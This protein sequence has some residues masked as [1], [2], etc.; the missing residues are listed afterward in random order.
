MIISVIYTSL[1]EQAS[2]TVES[3]Y[4]PIIPRTDSQLSGGIRGSKTS[5]DI[6]RSETPDKVLV[7]SSSKESEIDELTDLLMSSLKNNQVCFG[8]CAGKESSFNK[9][10]INCLIWGQF[11]YVQ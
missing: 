11:R 9:L 4:E 6:R 10:S 8:K 1:F 3:L 5:L 2:S 7:T